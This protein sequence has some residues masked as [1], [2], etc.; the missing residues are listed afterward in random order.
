MRG[1]R[2]QLI[3]GPAAADTSY[4]ARRLA[5]FLLALIEAISSADH[6]ARLDELILERGDS[7]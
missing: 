3:L 4:H 7:E 6:S 5:L 2:P 1:G